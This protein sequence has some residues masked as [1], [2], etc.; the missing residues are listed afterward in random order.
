[1]IL[2]WLFLKKTFIELLLNKDFTASEN[3]FS[4]GP[5]FR[6][7]CAVLCVFVLKDDHYEGGG[8]FKCR[9]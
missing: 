5:R 6:F 1:M 9:V 2:I 8:R 3:I 7:I 4:L